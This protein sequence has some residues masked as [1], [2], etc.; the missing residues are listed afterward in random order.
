MPRGASPKREREY[1]ELKTRFKKEHRYPGR[2]EEV[3]ARIVNKQRREYG[4]TKGERAKDRAGKSPDRNLPVDNYQHLT[5]PQVR[6]QL[7]RLSGAELR[8]VRSYERKNKQRRGVLEAI[9]KTLQGLSS[10]R[11]RGGKKTARAA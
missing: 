2:E 6:R 4:E 5:V 3:A 9:E 11:G 10:S 7:D 1:S 8:K